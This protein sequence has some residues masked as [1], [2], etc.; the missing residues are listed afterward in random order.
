MNLQNWKERYHNRATWGSESPV[1]F[2]AADIMNR[3]VCGSQELALNQLQMMYPVATSPWLWLTIGYL[4]MVQYVW[5]FRDQKSW[6]RS[7][8]LQSVCSCKAISAKKYIL[9]FPMTLKWTH[10]LGEVGKMEKLSNEWKVENRELETQRE[11][12][13]WEKATVDWRTCPC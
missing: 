1:S 8:T 6:T 5:S 2:R 11:W 3:E 9:Q 4:T 13:V 12:Q 10:A 7:K